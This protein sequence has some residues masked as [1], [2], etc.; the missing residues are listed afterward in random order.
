MRNSLRGRSAPRCPHAHSLLL[1]PH[2]VCVPCFTSVCMC[3]HGLAAH[4]HSLSVP[5]AA[6][7]RSPRGCGALVPEAAR[8]SHG[9]DTASVGQA[10]FS[11]P[12][13]SSEDGSGGPALAIGP[14]S[15]P[16]PPI[17]AAACLCPAA[18][19]P[20]QGQAQPRRHVTAGNSARTWR[21]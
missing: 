3:V 19:P 10:L 14:G 21:L 9:K 5:A 4:T 11:L 15:A 12:G 2:S 6:G 20:P 13:V 8:G 1:G 17:R 16:F 18:P 7:S